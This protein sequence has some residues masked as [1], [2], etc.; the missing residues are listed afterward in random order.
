MTLRVSPKSE[1]I[2]LYIDLKQEEEL[3]KW[4]HGRSGV[5]SIHFKVDISTTE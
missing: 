2:C 5:E 3:F 1:T 4:G